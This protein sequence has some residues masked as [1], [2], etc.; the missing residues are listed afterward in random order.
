[1]RK[2]LKLLHRAEILVQGQF[3]DAKLILVIMYQK[4]ITVQ[5]KSAFVSF[6]LRAQK[7]LPT[8]KIHNLRSTGATQLKLKLLYSLK[9]SDLEK[10]IISIAP[11]V[12]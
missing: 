8:L 9:F 12:V 2:K 6:Y 4:F 1:M 10:K 3:D 5:E 11:L 7:C